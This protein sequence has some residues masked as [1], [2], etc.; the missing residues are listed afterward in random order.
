MGWSIGFDS[1]WNR[2]IGY[3]VPATCDYPG[4]GED[5]DRGLSF[6]CGSEPRGGERGCGL[7]FCG[8]HLTGS[9]K[10]G[11]R[12]VWVCGRC[13]KNR[14]P[15]DPTPD[16]REWIEWKLTDESWAAWRVENPQA[17]SAM[18]AAISRTSLSG[19]PGSAITSNES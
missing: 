7:Y 5:I 4:C 14:A 19:Q 3:G 1:K 2:D 17:V 12:Y 15:Y 6:V 8:R 11:D 18:K 16:T 9:R 13:D 10:V